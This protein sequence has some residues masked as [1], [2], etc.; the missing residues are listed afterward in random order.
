MH[1][2]PTVGYM[3]SPLMKSLREVYLRFRVSLVFAWLL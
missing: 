3:D 2:K 1:I